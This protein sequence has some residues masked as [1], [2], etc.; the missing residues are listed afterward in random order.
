M[1][2]TL[3]DFEPFVQIKK[4]E[5][6]PWK[7]ITLSKV[8]GWTM[9]L[10]WKQYFSMV[11]LR[12]TAVEQNNFTAYNINLLYLKLLQCQAFKIKI[13]KLIKLI[14]NCILGSFIMNKYNQKSKDTFKGTLIQIWKSTNVLVFIWNNMSM[15]SH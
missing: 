11:F 13:D 1:C 6:L 9:Q 2:D 15:I 5:K 3:R 14:P 12:R 10:Y 8:A 4:R 7:S